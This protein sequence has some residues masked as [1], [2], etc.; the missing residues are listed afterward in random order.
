MGMLEQ[1]RKE[2]HPRCIDMLEWYTDYGAITL[3]NWNII[4]DAARGHL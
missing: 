1:A 3:V 2:Q 4:R